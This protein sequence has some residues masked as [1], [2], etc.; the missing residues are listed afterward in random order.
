MEDKA[1]S[2]NRSEKREGSFEHEANTILSSAES[3][4]EMFDNIKDPKIYTFAQT[5][6]STNHLQVHNR[7]RH[8]I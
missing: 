3:E 2:D 1:S 4:V 5:C 8:L 7:N 6:R